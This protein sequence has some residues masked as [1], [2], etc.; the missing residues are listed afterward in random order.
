MRTARVAPSIRPTRGDTIAIAEPVAE[1][2]LAC[3]ANTKPKRIVKCSR[4]Q[5][6]IGFARTREPAY[7]L[8]VRPKLN[9]IA[10]APQIL[11]DRIVNS[12]KATFQKNWPGY[13]YDPSTGL[14]TRNSN[15]R[16]GGLHIAV[17]IV[18]GLVVFGFLALVGFFVARKIRNSGGGVSQHATRDPSE[19]LKL[20]ADGSVLQEVMQSFERTPNSTMNGDPEA[21][22]LSLSPR[23]SREHSVDVGARGYSD[24]PGRSRR[25][26][27]ANGNGN[28]L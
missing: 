4:K 22:D 15:K 10:I 23:S 3:F 17:S 28:I 1:T 24:R 25:N 20:E 8:P 2:L 19:G 26:G 5:P 18:I 13:D 9:G 14:S 16:E 21:F 6:P 11:K 7:C 27:K 12:S